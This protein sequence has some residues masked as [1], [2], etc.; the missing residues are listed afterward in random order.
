MSISRR[1]S[2]LADLCVAVIGDAADAVSRWSRRKL[3]RHVFRDSD[4][5]ETDLEADAK[6]AERYGEHAAHVIHE[7]RRHGE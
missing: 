2:W 5:T 6:L 7:R 4:G 1:R 3:A